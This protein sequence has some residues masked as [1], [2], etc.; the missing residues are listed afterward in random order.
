MLLGRLLK[1]FSFL[2]VREIFQTSS[3]FFYLFRVLG[4]LLFSRSI[5]FLWLETDFY[6]IN[7]KGPQKRKEFSWPKTRRVCLQLFCWQLA[8]PPP[9]PRIQTWNLEKSTKVSSA[10]QSVIR[11]FIVA[12]GQNF[13]NHTYLE[14]SALILISRKD[15]GT[16]MQ[17][18]IRL[19][20]GTRVGWV[21]FFLGASY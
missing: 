6:L 14:K 17:F 18:F 20:V 4:R 2:G 8:N 9:P 3:W 16:I 19:H 5:N 11:S 12:D 10:I 13:K 7:A 1:F 15:Y 21:F